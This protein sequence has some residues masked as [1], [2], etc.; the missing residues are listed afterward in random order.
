MLNLLLSQARNRTEIILYAT[1]SIFI[2]SK[3]TS[4]RYSSHIVSTLKQIKINCEPLKNC[5]NRLFVQISYY[6]AMYAAKTETFSSERETG[7]SDSPITNSYFKL[8]LNN[9]IN[10]LSQFF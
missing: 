4:S 8:N 2:L 1:Q 10:N 6:I 7:Q 3:F 5:L 9:K